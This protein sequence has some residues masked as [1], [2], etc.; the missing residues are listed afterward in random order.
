MFEAIIKKISDSYA[1]LPEECLSSIILNVK[2]LN[3]SKG[4]ILVREGQYSDKIYYMVNGCARAYY[5]NDGRD[6]SDWFAFENNFISSIVSFFT[7]KPSPHYIE[8]LENSTLLEFSKEQVES[9]S[10]SYHEFEHLF[11]IVL[12][13]T[14]LHQRARIG[15]ILF[16]KADKRY[17]NLLELYPDILLR[18]PLTHIASYLG[19]T[20]E[21][22]SRI[23]HP[24]K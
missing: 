23:R 11:R 6:I 9:L 18:I 17:E 10:Q 8:V 13:E 4:S 2:V 21:T 5:L 12:T 22:L 7:G 14:T 1:P 3:K 20:L 19:M 15:A 16:Q 24:K